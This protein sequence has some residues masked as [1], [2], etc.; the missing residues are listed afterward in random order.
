M[1]PQQPQT[2][3]LGLDPSLF[4]P[5]PS[6]SALCS[7]RVRE[8]AEDGPTDCFL[9]FGCG[10]GLAA[11]GVGKQSCR[12]LFLLLQNTRCQGVRRMQES[13]SWVYSPHHF[14]QNLGKAWEIASTISSPKILCVTTSGMGN[15]ASFRHP[16]SVSL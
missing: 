12:S 11:Q 7:E 4:N 2:A 3:W 1:F 8:S 15:K 5:S 16:F 6:P 10:E 9:R 13:W 14:T